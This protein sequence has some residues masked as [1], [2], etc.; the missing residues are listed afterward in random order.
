MVHEA[1]DYDDYIN[2]LFGALRRVEEASEILIHLV[3]E[4]QEN[5]GDYDVTSLLEGIW[6]AEKDLKMLLRRKVLVANM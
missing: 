5:N 1:N 4:G 6:T 3:D 2:G